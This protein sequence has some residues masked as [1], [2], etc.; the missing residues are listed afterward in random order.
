MKM[1]LQE[2]NDF[3]APEKKSWVNEL[4]STSCMEFS[5]TKTFGQMF[6]SKDENEIFMH[7]MI[8]SCM[9]LIVRESHSK[10]AELVITKS[11]RVGCQKG[12][13]YANKR[14]LK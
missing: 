10:P 6:F 12:R 8:F 11:P 2:W 13:M 7:E 4:Y 9:K 1:S 14:M 5:L 3:S